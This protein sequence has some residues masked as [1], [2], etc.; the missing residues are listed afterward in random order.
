MV[1]AVASDGLKV[2]LFMKGG[3]VPDECGGWTQLFAQHVTCPG[4]DEI[5]TGRAREQHRR[6]KVS[7]ASGGNQ[8]GLGTT[9]AGMIATNLLPAQAPAIAPIGI[10]LKAAFI[11]INDV[12][13]SAFGNDGAQFLKIRQPLFRIALLVLQG[14]FLRVSFI[15]CNAQ[16]MLLIRTPKCG[17]RS[18]NSA[19]G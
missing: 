15:C 16:P 17:A 18:R 2:F 3:V 12:L 14:L 10:R 1:A 5:G 7:A 6:E 19:S 9:M 8:T 13:R 11:D 4:I